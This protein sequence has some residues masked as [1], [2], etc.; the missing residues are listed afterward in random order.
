MYDSIRETPSPTVSYKCHMITGSG[1]VTSSITS[2]HI[3]DTGILFNLN[4]VNKT[5]V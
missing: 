1:N 4:N 5:F 3:R 2:V